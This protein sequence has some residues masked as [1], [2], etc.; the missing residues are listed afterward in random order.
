MDD[1]AVL[2]RAM[3]LCARNG[4]LWNASQLDRLQSWE[5]NKTVLNEAGR[6]EYLARA[7]QELVNESETVEPPPAAA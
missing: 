1:A 7:R 6:R 3:D 2:C 5:R 4:A